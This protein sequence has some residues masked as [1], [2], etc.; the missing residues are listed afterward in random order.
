MTVR[1][2]LAKS[3]ELEDGQMK[4][5]EIDDNKVLL[6]RQGDEYFAFVGQ[7]PHHGAPLEDGVLC[8]GKIRCPWHQAVFDAR[9][10]QV[11]QPPSLDS[12]PQYRVEVVGGNVVAYLPREEPK[13]VETPTAPRSGYI[14]A[15]KAAEKGQY[16]AQPLTDQT[17][18][19][20]RN[21]AIIGSGAAGFL[22]A[23]TLRAQGFAGNVTI[24]TGE[25]HLPYDR[26]ELSKRFLADPDSSPPWL[27]DGSYLDKRG[28]DILYDHQVTAMDPQDRRL[29]CAS[30]SSLEYDELL[31]ASGSRPRRLDVEGADLDGVMTLRSYDDC[32]ELRDWADRVDKAVVIGASF[33]GMEVA[34]SLASRK[35]SMQVIAPED[36]PFEATLGP[37]IGRMLRSVHQQQDTQFHMGR[38]VKAFQG[39]DG[40]LEAV[41]LD[42]DTRIETELAVVGIGVEP[43]TDFL[44]DELTEEDG[45]IRVDAHLRHAAGFF[46]AGD[47]ARFDDPRA[48]GPVRI[49]HWRLAQQLGALAARNMAGKDATFQDVPFFWTKQ[50]KTIVQY[51]GFGGSWDQTEIEG[52]VSDQDFLVYYLCDGKVRGVAGGGRDRQMDLVAEVLARSEA[53]LQCRELVNQLGRCRHEYA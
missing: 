24:L 15:R 30:G 47:I 50:F 21:F 41:I 5:I 26:T 16:A 51:V 52:S 38:K 11:E 27:K 43:V 29:V 28:I 9:T 23:E 20:G 48:E 14:D 1:H 2:V 6:L 44:P 10:G 36:V 19:T 8:E 37:E 45:A 49:E 4:G 35:I 33:I 34:A 46:A 53:P 31:I 22:A 40:K 13:P 7:C 18:G 39:R 42:D 3:D 25:Q 12:L 32:R 17:F